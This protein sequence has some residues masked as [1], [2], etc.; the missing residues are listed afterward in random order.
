MLRC[1][2]LSLL[3]RFDGRIFLSA[4]REEDIKMS[5]PEN[6][7]DLYVGE[8]QDLWSANDQM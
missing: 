5:T 4:D 3:T 6:L 7:F 8:L 1:R 2:V